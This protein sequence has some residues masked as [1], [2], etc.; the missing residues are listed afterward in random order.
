MFHYIN[1]NNKVDRWRESFMRLNRWNMAK[2]Q[3]AKII[4]FTAVY[5]LMFLVSLLITHKYYN[6]F[7]IISVIGIAQYLEKLMIRRIK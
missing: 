7:I 6:S 2:K 1:V 3:K 4:Y 5:L